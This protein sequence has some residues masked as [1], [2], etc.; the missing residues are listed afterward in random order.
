MKKRSWSLGYVLFITA[1]MYLPILAVIVY[2][3]SASKIS[4]IW[5]GFSM[6]WY[7]TFIH[8][9][10]MLKSIG[11]SLIVAGLSSLTAAVLGTMI[12][13]ITVDRKNKVEKYI[14]NMM[15]LPLIIPEVVLG[16]V[17]MAFYS[18]LH[19]PQGFLTL[20]L[21]H[22]TFCIP[23]VAIMVS[24]SLKSMDRS[25]VEAARD[26]GSGPI[27]A[28]FRVEL[29]LLTPGILSGSLFAFAMSFD[30]VIISVFVS[31]PKTTTLPLKVYTS[32]KTI[33]TPEINA[34]GTVSLL[35]ALLAAGLFFLVYRRLMDHE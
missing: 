26:L 12:A 19:I 35:V 8:D 17:L 27:G 31:G 25:V 20:W 33:P 3:F 6:R 15:L 18:Y 32:M 7:E 1:L 9:R 11:N 16:M 4:G 30:D 21:S 22:S 5:G 28:F 23:Y 34:V 10:A 29:P 2:S 13:L 14:E 24:S